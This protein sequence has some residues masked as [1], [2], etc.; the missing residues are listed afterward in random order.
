M[1]DP[2]NVLLADQLPVSDAQLN[3]ERERALE[4]IA[5]NLR[6]PLI[7]QLNWCVLLTTDSEHGL[8]AKHLELVAKINRTA[9]DLLG[10]V[11]ETL[12]EEKIKERARSAAPT[13]ISAPEGEALT[14]VPGVA[15][16]A[17]TG[18]ES[19]E[20]LSTQAAPVGVTAPSTCATD[21][22]AQRRSDA[23]VL[24]VAGSSSVR[25][26]LVGALRP[27]FHV[28]AAADGW[29][30]LQL[31]VERPDVIVSEVN[32]ERVDFVDLVGHA[33][34]MASDVAVLAMHDA[35]D[36]ALLA[37]AQQRGVREFL[38]K[39][40]PIAAVVDKVGVLAS[41]RGTQPNK[42][43]LVVC[44]DPHE[45]HALY[46]L[47]DA[48]Y[49]THLAPSIEAARDAAGTCFD[50]LIVDTAAGDGRWQ[51]VVVRHRSSNKKIPV[52]ALVDGTCRSIIKPLRQL[53]VNAALRKPYSCDD[54]LAQ[55]RSLLG[56][57]EMDGRVLRSVLRRAVI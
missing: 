7:D 5:Q 22:F 46:H 24:V 43:V 17:G 35:W 34:G 56:I 55:V 14:P 30:A 37:V 39:P 32:L 21:L 16:L 44:P 41:S 6:Q 10:Q 40:F 23:K 36:G 57:K 4:T 19:Q 13:N 49:R 53:R 31:M 47:L 1:S 28:L 9:N 20:G 42:S 33:R 11:Q 15:T 45:G 54:L 3:E 2:V 27:M 29:E 52:L 38:Q 26:L 8:H 50:V 51:E 12:D 48:R 25:E 18:C